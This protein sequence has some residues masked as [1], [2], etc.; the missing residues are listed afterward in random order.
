MTPETHQRLRAW[1]KFCRGRPPSPQEPRCGSAESMW[2]PQ[3]GNTYLSP[4][5]A[6]AQSLGHLPASPEQ[7]CIEV[8]VIVMRMPWRERHALRL[9]YVRG[10]GMRMSDKAREL[11]IRVEDYL[12]LVERAGLQVERD[13]QSP[14]KRARTPNYQPGIPPCQANQAEQAQQ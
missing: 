10:R 8:E 9:E 12:P 7:P 5:E 3:A 13:L 1:G 2:L 4:T 14:S 11:K 6:L